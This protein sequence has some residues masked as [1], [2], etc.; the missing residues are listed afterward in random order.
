MLFLRQKFFNQMFYQLFIVFFPVT[1]SEVFFSSIFIIPVRWSIF[2][3]DS[4]PGYFRLF[5]EDLCTYFHD[6]CS[7]IEVIIWVTLKQEL[8]R[9]SEFYCLYIFYLIFCEWFLQSINSLF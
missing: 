6:F 7:E 9:N 1:A 4:F 3:F 2:S 8:E 5:F